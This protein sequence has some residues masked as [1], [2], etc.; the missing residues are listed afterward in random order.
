M[1]K[2]LSITVIMLIYSFFGVQAQEKMK[3]AIMDFSPG[4]G[5]DESTVNG[6]SDM[7]INSLFDLRKFTIIERNQLEKIITELGFQKTDLTAKQIAEVG[8]ILGVKAMLVGR[9]NFNMTSTSNGEY[10]IDIR[11]VDV[12]SGEIISTAGVTKAA[13]QTYR[14]LMKDLA[15]QLEFKMFESNP[16]K[17]TTSY[18]KIAYIDLQEIWI[19]MP[20]LSEVNKK[21]EQ[22]TNRITTELTAMENRIN[23]FLDDES[24]WSN[25]IR[26]SKLE[27]LQLLQ[28][29]YIDYKQD[30]PTNLE[31]MRTTLTEP[32][33]DKIITAM[34][35]VTDENNLAGIMDISTL[36]YCDEKNNVTSLVKQK[37]GITK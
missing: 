30:A 4:V 1:R 6:L 31:Q 13:N 19:S 12:E 37:L 20:E 16:P 11:I 2:I 32:I 24:R 15:K 34:Q 18:N 10:N 17:I 9:V 3:I 27:E 5:V 25:S 33:R 23:S 21:L 8:K 28:K 22:E 35:S 7:L 26:E 14:D 29:S 36:L